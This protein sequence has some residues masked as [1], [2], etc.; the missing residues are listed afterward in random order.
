[1]FIT[2]L[3][4]TYL[5]HSDLLC[6]LNAIKGQVRMPDEIVIVV[7]PGDNQSFEIIDQFHFLSDRIRV[8]GANKPSVVHSLNI[9]LAVSR[10]ELICLTD[11][12]S[13]PPPDWIQ[14]IELHF[15]SNPGVGAVGGRDRLL[16]PSEPKL[17]NPDLVKHVGFVTW[18][19]EIIGNHHCGSIKSPIEVDVLKG[20]NLS[21][22]RSAFSFMCIDKELEFRGAEVG[23][24]AD[25]CLSIKR[26]G[27]KLVF[28]NLLIVD[29]SVGVRS[30]DDNR[31]QIN[32]E[33]AIKRVENNSYLA[34]KYFPL[35]QSGIRL[36]YSFFRGSRTSPGLIILIYFLFKGEWFYIKLFFKVIIAVFRGHFKGVKIRSN[37]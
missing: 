17:S 13:I 28:D 7:G 1:M 11:D 23:W 25:I 24:E 26:N 15:Q 29:H 37:I 16:L 21:F 36:I 27:F 8:V 22:K 3:F 5:R 10:G 30:K 2:L 34:A 12:D 20:V 4:P 31:L 19:G 14:R 9:G 33:V 35:W 6:L 32:N 18:Y